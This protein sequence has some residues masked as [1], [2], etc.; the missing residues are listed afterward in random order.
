MFH[1]H[2]TG[3]T[4]KHNIPNKAAS[5]KNNNSM[6]NL[7]CRNYK[8]HVPLSPQ[9][10]I[11]W[12]TTPANNK[13]GF[14]NCRTL[15]TLSQ[16]SL[17]TVTTSCLVVLMVVSQFFFVIANSVCLSSVLLS[18]FVQRRGYTWSLTQKEI[19]ARVLWNW[20]QLV[21]F[22]SFVPKEKHTRTNT[23]TNIQF[24]F[25]NN[26]NTAIWTTRMRSF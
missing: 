8:L 1:T 22:C 10:K 4:K 2:T 15:S 11:K 25:F 18:I 16:A 21:S 12:R 3:G 26:T 7:S 6:D 23:W 20:H 5:M 14:P 13:R 9:I 17:R 24:I 19:S